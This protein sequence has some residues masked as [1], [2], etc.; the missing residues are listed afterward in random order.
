MDYLNQLGRHCEGL[1]NV[2][3]SIVGTAGFVFGALRYLK[4]LRTA[5]EPG[6][7]QRTLREAH[8]R[9]KRLQDCRSGIKHYSAAV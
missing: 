2:I 9:L 5:S 8:S 7:G 1:F 6:L 3:G 4:E